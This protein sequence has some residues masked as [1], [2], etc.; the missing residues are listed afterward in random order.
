MSRNGFT[1]G[2]HS[3]S[4][5]VLSRLSDA[6]CREEIGRARAA[7]DAIPGSTRSLAYPFGLYTDSIRQ[8]ARD[9]GYTVLMGVEGC[10]DP[11]DLSPRRSSQRDI[12]LAGCLVRDDGSGRASQVSD[13]AI[14]EN[15]PGA[16]SLSKR[17][18]KDAHRL[19]SC[20][21]RSAVASGQATPAVISESAFTKA[22]MSSRVVNGPGLRRS[23]PSGKVPRARWI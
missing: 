17:P 20:C 8:I 22:A 15:N 9:L 10:N 23:V 2:N 16:F 5:A 11:L 19:T 7:L 18:L 21:R 6:E 13:Q 12:D 1:F 14:L 4:H 3:A